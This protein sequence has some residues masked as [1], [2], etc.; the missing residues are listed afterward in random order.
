MRFKNASLYKDSLVSHLNR[1]FMSKTGAIIIIEDDKDDRDI[2]VEVIGEL[3]IENKL[4]LFD[5]CLAAFDYLKTTS[6]HPFIIFCDVNLPQQNGIDFKRQI[7]DDPY[8][9][10]KSIPFVFYSTSVAQYAVNEA[11]TQMTVQGFF[12]KPNSYEEIRHL[13]KLI[14]HYWKHC[15]HPNAI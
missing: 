6:D 2:L 5:N 1:L 11:Y 12:Q 8:L 4:V 10:K 14:L 15:K 9:R 3:Q 7:D 13:V